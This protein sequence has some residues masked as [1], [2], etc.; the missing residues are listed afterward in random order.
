M[1]EIRNIDGALVA[2]IEEASGTIVIINRGCVTKI[3]YNPD[4]SMEITNT[5]ENKQKS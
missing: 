4:G 1:K 3:C 2:K 5:K